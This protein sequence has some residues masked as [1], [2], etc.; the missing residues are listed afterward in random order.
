M[1]GRVVSID[2]HRFFN[3]W[4]RLVSLLLAL[5]IA[6]LLHSFSFAFFLRQLIPFTV[7][8]RKFARIQL[9]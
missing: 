8:K 9:G 3:D 5:F 2:F 1:S 7:T 6:M 4:Y